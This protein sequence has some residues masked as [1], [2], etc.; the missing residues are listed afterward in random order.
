MFAG[1]AF[2]A[3]LVLWAWRCFGCFVFLWVGI[4]QFVGE[5][6]LGFWLATIVGGV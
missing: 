5:C 1:L 4:I 2:C 6:W 3:L